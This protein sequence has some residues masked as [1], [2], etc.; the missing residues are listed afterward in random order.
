MFPGMNPRK[1]Q[2]MMKQMGVQQVD[3]PATEVIIKTDEKEIIITSPSVAKVNMMGQET[4]QISGTIEERALL[5]TPD[6]SE[7]DVNTVMEQ[8]HVDKDT[9]QKAIEDHNGDLA[10]AIMSLQKSDE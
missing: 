9:A 7:D 2:Q 5:T 4:F 1:V 8:A 3:I 10:E 6:I